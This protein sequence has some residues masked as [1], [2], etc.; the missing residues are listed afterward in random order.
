MTL[1]VEYIHGKNLAQY[2]NKRSLSQISKY[3][4]NQILFDISDGIQHIHSQGIIHRDIKPENIIL[5]QGDR[6]AVLCDFGIS[7]EASTSKAGFGGGTPCY[8]SP[9][10]IIGERSYP[11]DIW[12]FGVTMLYVTGMLPIPNDTW[13]IADV[14]KGGQDYSEMTQWLDKIEEIRKNL[15]EDFKLFRDMLVDDAHERITASALVA[16][17]QNLRSKARSSLP[18]KHVHFLSH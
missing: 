12:A 17:L 13:V 10:Y 9:E 18:K 2:A 11:S 5:G 15:S 16:H 6:G 8:I 7:C 14:A 1:Y 3:K 4:Q